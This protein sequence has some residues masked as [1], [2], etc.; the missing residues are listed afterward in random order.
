VQRPRSRGVAGACT[1]WRDL[2]WT[3]ISLAVHDAIMRSPEEVL[4]GTN[5]S[6]LHHAYGSA[7]GLP[8]ILRG[9]LSRDP[10]AAGH[11][12]GTLDAALLHQGDICS[13][14]APAALFVA[15]CLTDARTDIICASSLPWDDRT[16]PLRAALLEWLGNVGES[17]SYHDEH[18]HDTNEAEQAC[19]T[20]RPEL[21]RAIAPFLFNDNASIRSAAL[22]AAGRLLY[23]PDLAESRTA[24]AQ[25]L[26]EP[27]AW[28][29]PAD[30]ARIALIL[31]DWSIP[32]RTLLDDG[33]PA[34]RACAAMA[35]TL[36]DDPDALAAIRSALRDPNAVNG[37]FD[38][39]HPLGGG[40][41]LEALVQV[42]LR[43]TRT[44]EDIEEEATAIALT[45]ES[46]A[47]QAALRTLWLR[48]F[49][50]DVPETAAE[51]RFSELLDRQKRR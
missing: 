14:T 46:Y 22:V 3:K 21:F 17:A 8:K 48:A 19:Q 47:R 29:E 24:V 13:S 42:L 51:R 31:D 40:W 45:P 50:P 1:R 32:P 30:R 9:L 25:Q 38:G 5:W 34:V 18:P 39:D 10:V 27:G 37:W 23:A 2:L 33:D 41:L 11:A 44:F 7:D 12:L 36:D 28:A 4:A 49:P 20:I 43:R 26:L 16:R 35:A 6:L 15:S